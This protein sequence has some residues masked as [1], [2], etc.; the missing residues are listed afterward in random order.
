MKQP[1]MLRLAPPILAGLATSAVVAAFGLAGNGND[2][3]N[4]PPA[5]VPGTAIGQL[6]LGPVNTDPTSQVTIPIQSFSW[7]ISN[8]TSTGSSSGGAGAGK[9]SLSSM[10]VMKAVDTSSAL[11]L[12]AAATGNHFSKGVL[13]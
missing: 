13:N 1:R 8:P 12:R 4:G 7:G 9:A 2:N 3:G 11:L 6:T 5:A 10:N